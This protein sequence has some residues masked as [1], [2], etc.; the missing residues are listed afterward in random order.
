MVSESML[1]R[2]VAIVGVVATLLLPARASD[3]QTAAEKE[4]ARAFMDDGRAKFDAG[5]H[6]AALDAFGAADRIMGVTST[7]LWVGK[8]LVVL[9]RLID[10]RDKL[11]AVSQIPG[12]EAESPVLK[13]ARLEAAQLQAELAEQIGGLK[14]EISGVPSGAPVRV[15]VD[16]REL[17]SDLVA[18]PYRVDPGEHLVVG[19]SPGFARRK[20]RVTVGRGDTIKVM[21][22]LKPGDDGG[23]A[24][25]DG[26]DDGVSIHP[27]VWAGFGTAA[28]GLLVGAIT[29]GVS[30]AD[31]SSAKE[32]CV[33]NRCPEANAADAD[34]SVALAHVSTVSFVVGGVGAGL[35]VAGL[36]LSDGVFG[37]SD[38]GSA[39]AWRIEPIVGPG[40][41][42]IRGRF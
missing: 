15:W 4:T 42:G 27:L 26:D 40:S 25:G 18:R 35:G 31:A 13:R 17:S 21:L 39:D 11:I 33:D 30:L 23:D 2:A 34:R 41:L 14:I 3:A 10:A 7:G 22:V 20:L 32:G 5:D 9:G 29:G 16:G 12:A 1:F 38:D 28:A 8:T 19:T 37:A 36:F 6:D 24:G